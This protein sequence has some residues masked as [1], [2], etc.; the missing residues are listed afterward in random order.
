MSVDFRDTWL[1]DIDAVIRSGHYTWLPRGLSGKPVEEA[2]VTLTA[3]IMHLCKRSGIP[4]DQVRAAAEEQFRREEE[5]RT[6]RAERTEHSEVAAPSC[7]EPSSAS[8][9]RASQT[10]HCKP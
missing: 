3:D 4:W 10:A 7:G 5:E 6:R 1:R 9:S 2:M 8:P